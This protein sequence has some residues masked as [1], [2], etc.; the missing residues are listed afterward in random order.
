MKSHELTILRVPT[1]R[2]QYLRETQITT[3]LGLESLQA[4]LFMYEI[5]CHLK[6]S[7]VATGPTFSFLTL[8]NAPAG[9]L[10]VENKESGPAKLYKAV[11]DLVNARG[12]VD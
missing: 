4:R 11:D 2:N 3:R 5:R 1:N 8:E 9:H 12:I 6:N 10:L 7:S